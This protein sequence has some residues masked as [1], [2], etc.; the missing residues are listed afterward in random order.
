MRSH[1]PI[2][3]DFATLYPDVQRLYSDRQVN[4]NFYARIEIT[5]Q[6]IS[7]RTPFKL[8]RK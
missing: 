5:P 2:N 3:Y 7:Q 1:N 6:T 8:K 4:P